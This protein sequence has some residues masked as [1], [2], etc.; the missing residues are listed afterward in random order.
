MKVSPGI[1]SIAA[2]GIGIVATGGWQSLPG[3]TEVS[4]QRKA[5]ALSKIKQ[6]ALGIM[7]YAADYDDVYPSAQSTGAVKKLVL[8]YAKDNA[9]W[10]SLNPNGGRILVNMGVCGVALANI[11]EPARWPLLF[12][13]RAWPDGDHLVAFTDGHGKWIAAREWPSVQP[14]FTKKLKRVGKPHPVH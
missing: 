10:K 8:P 12:D 11:P 4:G 7:I 6:L 14:F 5:Q 2:L 13:E 3:G 1:T 9:L